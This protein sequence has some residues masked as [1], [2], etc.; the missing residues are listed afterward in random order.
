MDVIVQ[1]LRHSVGDSRVYCEEVGRTFLQ[2]VWR[3]KKPPSPLWEKEAIAFFA[4]LVVFDQVFSRVSLCRAS[5]LHV[6]SAAH[7]MRQHS[8]GDCKDTKQPFQRRF[9]ARLGRSIWVGT[10]VGAGV[11]VG[12][13][14]AVGVGVSVCCGT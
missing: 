4:S 14:V 8:Q 6:A 10:S 5:R 2:T 12:V 3:S 1:Q 9:I 7:H 11:A 13:D